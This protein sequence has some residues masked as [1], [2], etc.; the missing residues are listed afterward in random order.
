MD[1]IRM[2]IFKAILG[3]TNTGKT[4]YAIE[5][6]MAYSSGMIGL[7]L[8]LLARE[9][10]DKIVAKKGSQAVALITGEERL[11][12]ASASYYVCTTESMPVQRNVDFMAV[13]EIQL[14]EDRDR[15]H[16]FTERILNA[17]GQA[18]TLLLGSET[19]R[20]V[21]VQLG[22]GVQITTR[23][24]FSRLIYGGALK[25]S[26]LP[27]RSA[28]IG[29]SAEEVYSI[30]EF[31]RQ[32]KG[33]AA[34]VMGALSP[35]TRNAQ[36][37]LYQSGEVDYIVATDAIGMGLNLDVDYVAFSNR[38]KFDGRYH[39]RLSAAE[40]GQIA[41][42]AGRFRNEGFFGETNSCPPFDS[43]TVARIEDHNFEPIDA[44][45]WRN[46]DLDF[47]SINSL[48]YSL[49]VYS[50]S[51]VLHR[52]SEA[53][54]EWVLKRLNEDGKLA[55]KVDTEAKVRRVWDLV[56]LPD[57]RRSGYDGHARLVLGLIDRLLEP[58]ARIPDLIMSNWL[59]DISSTS[60]GINKLQERLAAV[61]TWSYVAHRND[62]LANPITWRQRVREI[63]DRLSDALHDALTARF[64]DKRTKFLLAGIKNPDRLKGE[65]DSSGE[66]SVNGLS[67]GF[68][69]GLDFKLAKGKHQI[70]N[71]SALNLV[72][73]IVRPILDQKLTE[74]A[75]ASTSAFSLS[76]EAV[77]S[78][79]DVEIARLA[80]GK[81]WLLPEIILIGGDIGSDG[82]RKAVISRLYEWLDWRVSK[83]L[84]SHY[85][86]F[87]RNG[88]QKLSSVER[89]FAY[90]VL[91][92]GGAVD[93]RNDKYKSLLGHK[94]RE[95][96][97]GTGVRAGR[98]AAYTPEI[99]HVESLKLLATLLTVGKDTNYHLENIGTKSFALDKRIAEEKLA[100]L[101]YLRFGKRAVRADVVESLGWE[102]S[103]CR[104]ESENPVFRVP[105]SLKEIVACSRKEFVEVLKGCGLMRVKKG[106]QGGEVELWRFR[107]RGKKKQG[108]SSE[109]KRQGKSGV[110]KR[111]GSDQNVTESTNPFSE[112][113][114]LFSDSPKTANKNQKRR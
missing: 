93:L 22:I 62:W 87:R 31:L 108:E 36:V 11:E 8:R 90:Q 42:R 48:I 114:N 23:E 73:S 5:R 71:R 86:L 30:A 26:R 72:R 14:A 97:R 20:S 85:Q 7:P 99:K 39:R 17:R 1:S 106:E 49:S 2:A 25:I 65:I 52:S 16:I 111:R 94:E 55:S 64:V 74:V 28:V 84:K 46:S 88:L 112:L 41:G 101:G 10:Y 89:G 57:F 100:A 54:D 77:I 4:H 32:K 38:S 12:P 82:C 104:K 109:T 80:K 91:E 3:P 15:G 98:Y 76:R 66:I 107:G 29:F 9:V 35:R 68:L 24:R 21:L 59:K 63:E 18:E 92:S 44:L 61:R 6:M 50:K 51:Q 70:E 47:S 27:K 40:C 56:R 67:M 53:I 102:L 81:S 69:Q 75:T 58:D 19:M 34:I 79:K 95:V 113:A 45:Q 13:D 33:A 103:K 110:P 78:Y 60:G 96:L 105:D 37:A 83:L 43:E